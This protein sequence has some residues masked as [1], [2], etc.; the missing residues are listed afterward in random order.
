M[1]N[2]LIDELIIK[3]KQQGAKPTEK[4]IK[5]VGE[6][7]E[8]AKKATNAFNAATERTP[9]YLER[10][11]R[12]AEKTAN[13]LSKVKLNLSS[14]ATEKALGAIETSLE[15]LVEETVDM[16]HSMTVMSNN[17][18]Q[19]FSNLATD[20]GAD[21]ERVEDGLIDVRTEAGKTGEALIKVGK[22][23]TKAGRGLANQNRQGR[24]SARTFSDMAKFAGP[25]PLLYANIAANVFALSEAF[26]LLTE[27]EQLNRLEEV[28]TIIGAKIGTPVQVIGRQ[29]QELTGNTISYGDALRNAAAAASYGFDS[30]QIEQLTS[31]ARRASIALGVD[32]QDA[33]NRV[34]RG[35]SKLEIELLDELGITTKLT[36][37]YE[38][39]AQKLGL[40]ADKL[41][42]Y[43]QRA[44][45]VNE[46][47]QQSIEKLG[48]LDAMLREGAPWEQFGANASTAFQE[49]TMRISEAT[50]FVPQFF[51]EIDKKARDMEKP[52]KVADE[53]LESFA[54]SKDR[55]GMIG[56][57]IESSRQ[58]ENMQ[59]QLTTL[60]EMN[61]DSFAT[62]KIINYKDKVNNLV[63]AIS[64]LQGMVDDSTLGIPSLVKA[65]GA[66]RNLLSVVK[67]SL[68]SYETSLA[69]IKGQSG[70]YEK[71]YSDVLN[72]QK[73]YSLLER[74][75]PGFKASET[76]HTLGFESKYALDQA[77]AL[78]KSYRDANSALDMFG[79]TS[80]AVALTQRTLGTDASKV[81]LV[82][83]QQ[84]LGIQEQLLDSQIKLGMY[85]TKRAATESR[86][87]KLK[88]QELDLLIAIK[89]QEFD[90][91]S[92]SIELNNSTQPELITKQAL[93]ALERNRLATLEGMV[94]SQK[95]QEASLNRV[96][97]L[98]NEILASQTAQ[99]N[100]MMNSA[101]GNLA[102]FAPGIDQMTSSVNSL[103]MSFNN[104][105][106]SSMTSTQ[107][108]SSG[109][110]AFQG[111]LAYAS[112]DAIN[113][114]D[115]QI[116]AEKKRDGKSKESVAKIAA[117]EKK[118]V[119]QQK[120]SAKQQILISTAVAVMNAAANPWPVP[121]IP[122]MAAA[123]V[124]GGLAFSQASSASSNM[125]SGATGGNT[126]SLTVGKRSN[127]IDVSQSASKG[128]LSYLRN[129][130]GIGSAQSFTPRA[131]GGIGTP[132]NSLIVGEEG[133]EV[134][135][136]LEPIRV[137]NAE[138]SKKGTGT[139]RGS[140]PIVFDISA[141][142][143]QSIVD[144]AEDIFVAV[145]RA[146]NDRGLTLNNL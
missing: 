98:E 105:G 43:Q 67:G 112:N 2:K 57:L 115:Q 85:P 124:A 88:L 121:A 63:Y 66:Y 45:L 34:I 110:T 146:A 137:Y 71:L 48:D 141:I 35:T 12:A 140:S 20:L 68:P 127:D 69:N 80:S 114:V 29:M 6:A 51:N 39:Y 97:Q 17:L 32:M 77:V 93:L 84:E 104:M 129:E 62:A 26:R 4:A 136:P 125:M 7:L 23:A 40:S 106:Q 109:L 27:G 60:S 123:A 120:K 79:A 64:Q 15:T 108:I 139:G 19:L 3:V 75:D 96:K 94:G 52:L 74:T 107:M 89:N 117:L 145:E 47:N 142:D 42:S 22:G 70:A 50:S 131:N 11:E 133:P 82:T 135:T 37:A 72:M 99:S 33:M 103:A 21:L 132:G 144:R 143:A 119:E 91:A 122:L 128:E 46:I 130:S 38:H 61:T 10:V 76:L 90:R 78:A 118:K 113:S 59:G 134:I 92:T 81:N 14:A 49:F 83:L 73:A 24:N 116:A 18:I 65:D 55:G 30:E 87:N 54:S 126:A 31:A 138:D 100:T 25:L 41:N 44:A 5:G 56:L 1:A 36:T 95:E 9:K 28:G 58:I 101:L 16:N 13:R 86:I 8:E 53:L 111:M 102:S